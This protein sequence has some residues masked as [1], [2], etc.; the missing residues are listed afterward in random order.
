[1]GKD[2]MTVAEFPFPRSV[3]NV[4]EGKAHA[5]MPVIA[6]ERDD[7][8]AFKHFRFSSEEYGR[9]FFVIYSRREKPITA[10]DLAQAKY[11]LRTRALKSAQF[12]A[13]A[14]KLAPLLDK[15]F[16]NGASFKKALKAKLSQEEFEKYSE[17]LALRA[18]PYNIHALN[19]IKGSLY[20]FPVTPQPTVEIPLKMLGRGRIDAY[21]MAQDDCDRV[22]KD[23][24]LKNIHRSPYKSYSLRFII[25][26]GEQGE[27]TDRALT[28]ALN[29]MK[30]LGPLPV[31]NRPDYLDW[32]PYE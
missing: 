30:S 22:I 12:R 1:M 24:K 9:V 21:V 32:Q 17:D 31:V 10:N 3:S 20:D 13:V 25:P 11:V 16:E 15:Q 23:L 19:T 28:K 6:P 5:H 14:E 7:S 4:I 18:F 2:K 26:T 29:K 8:D 27:K